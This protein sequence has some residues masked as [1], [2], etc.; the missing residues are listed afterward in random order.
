MEQL[1]V[2]DHVFHTAASQWWFVK[3]NGVFE[4]ADIPETMQFDKKIKM[5]E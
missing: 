2:F 3:G 4:F 1:T 5:L